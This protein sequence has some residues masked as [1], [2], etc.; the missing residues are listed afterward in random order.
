MAVYFILGAFMERLGTVKLETE[1]LILTKF[2]KEMASDMFN[3]WASSE[4]VTKFLTWNAHKSIFDTYSIIEQWEKSYQNSDFYQWAIILKNCG[5]VVGSISVVDIN[6]EKEEVITGYCIGENWW[7]K[8]IT[9][10]AYKSII[11]FLFNEVKVKKIIGR[12]DK[13]NPNSGKVMIKCG[14]KYVKTIIAKNPKDSSKN[15]DLF[16]YELNNPKN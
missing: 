11:N 15:I 7:G 13:N 12:H 10:E 1:R 16:I 3:N 5:T 8:G 4:I 14:L 2:N 6:Y 9:A